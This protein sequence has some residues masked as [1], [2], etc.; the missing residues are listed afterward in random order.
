[1]KWHCQQ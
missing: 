1:L